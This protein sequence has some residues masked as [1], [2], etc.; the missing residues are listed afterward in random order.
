MKF[1]FKIRET[2][3]REINVEANDMQEAEDVLRRDYDEERIVLDWSD[4]QQ[5]E[6]IPVFQL[7]NH[8]L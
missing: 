1:K 4:F 2:L 5:V 6:F 8:H 7:C 3:Y